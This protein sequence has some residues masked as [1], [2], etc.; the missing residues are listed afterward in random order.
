MTERRAG[1]PDA[2]GDFCLDAGRVGA[3][4]NL[5]HH[6]RIDEVALQLIDDHIQGDDDQ[7]LADAAQGESGKDRRLSISR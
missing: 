2:L 1:A 5:A 4:P 3:Q 6:Q 7:G